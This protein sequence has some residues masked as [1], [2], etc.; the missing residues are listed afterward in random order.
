M[1]GCVGS[2]THD[3][4]LG[5]RDS[6]A[7]HN[8]RLTAKVEALEVSVKSL[9]EE[10]STALEEYEDLRIEKV[11]L[12]ERASKLEVRATKLSSD[13]GATTQDLAVT[14]AALAQAEEEVNRLG[15]TYQDLVTDLEKELAAG[16]I[17]IEQLRE[18]IRLNVSDDVLFASGSA[19]LDPIGREVLTSVSDKLRKLD[20]MIE[21]QGHTDDRR[22]SRRLAR[23][24]PSNWELAGARAARVVRLLLDEGVDGDRLSAVSY[25]SYRP[26]A[27]NDTP[28]GRSLNR[29]IEIR[30]LP[31]RDAMSLAEMEA[32]AEM[33]R[34]AE[35]AED[36]SVEADASAG[37][38][39]KE[40]APTI[41]SGPAGRLLGGAMDEASSA[42]D[43]GAG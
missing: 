22:I 33:A 26:L 4:L 30:L 12:E 27:S 23:R 21:V 29:R 28:E 42:A 10:L 25:A 19:D 5:E 43:G 37:D 8:D 13:L 31:R 17:Q 18:G 34:S 41:S 36:T 20:H 24:Y 40:M 1:T 3:S 39:G 35:V 32:D 6:L 2:G 14:Q 15:R 16:Q 38:T 11:R 9:E 7:L